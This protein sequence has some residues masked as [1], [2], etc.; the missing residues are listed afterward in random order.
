MKVRN[1]ATGLGAVVALLAA[2][3][4]AAEDLVTIYDRALANDPLIREADANRLAQRQSRPLAI[5]NLLP[6]VTANAGR[7]RNWGEQTINGVPLPGS[8]GSYTTRDTW[9]V[10]ITQPIFTW[11]NWVALRSANSQVAQAEADYQAQLQDLAQRVAQLYF[12]V[13][14]ARDNLELAKTLWK[15]AYDEERRAGKKPEN[16]NDQPPPDTQN[17]SL[18]RNNRSRSWPKMASS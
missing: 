9:S 6:G 16:P 8:T 10:N 7:Q 5:A 15:R 13:L 18:R 11:E 1:L 12:A 3:T 14:N 17:Q 2:G 4:A